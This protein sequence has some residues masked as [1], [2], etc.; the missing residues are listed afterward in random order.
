MSKT[1]SYFVRLI[2]VQDDMFCPG[3]GFS[4][5]YGQFIIG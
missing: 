2:V 5:R 4:V 3:S 1:T